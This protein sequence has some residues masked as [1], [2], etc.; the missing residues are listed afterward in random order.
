MATAPMWILWNVMKPC[1]SVALAVPTGVGSSYM[2]D[3]G[4]A[5]TSIGSKPCYMPLDCLVSLGCTHLL[6]PSEFFRDLLTPRYLSSSAY[7]STWLWSVQLKRLGFELRDMLIAS[8]SPRWNSSSSMSFLCM[9]EFQDH[10]RG[11]SPSPFL[12]CVQLNTWKSCC[13]QQTVWWF[14][15]GL[16]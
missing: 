2:G 8:H 14:N 11:V 12:H 9:P 3:A 5:E 15:V 6:V 16:V 10:F 7:L 4:R 13:P 1:S